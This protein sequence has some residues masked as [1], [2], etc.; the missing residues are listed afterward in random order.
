M[1]CIVQVPTDVITVKMAKR[2][3][4]NQLCDIP[5][6]MTINGIIIIL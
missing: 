3:L 1:T 5:S 2:T 4:N 6:L